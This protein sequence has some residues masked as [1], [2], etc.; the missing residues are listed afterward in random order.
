MSEMT[1][2]PDTATAV[3]TTPRTRPPLSPLAHLRHDLR[4][5]IG[6]ILG[7]A[8]ILMEDAA[9]AGQP[10]SPD[11]E[12]IYQ[13]GK[14]LLALVDERVNES[15]L[16]GHAPVSPSPVVRS[17]APTAT[18]PM[19]SAVRASASEQGYLLIADDNEENREIL[20]RQL[21]RLGH[22]TATVS[23]GAEAIALLATESFDLILLDL[24][25]P[26]LDGYQTLQQ[27]K[28]D[29]AIANTPVIMVTALD[30]IESAARCI[31]MGAADYLTKPFNPTLLRAR[32]N[33]SLRTKWARDRENQL[34]A[35]LQENYEKLLAAE[36]M[37][38]DLTGMIVHDLR[39]PLTSVLSG[40]M[41]IDSLGTLDSG[42]QEMLSISIHGAETLLGMINDLLDISK[43]EDGSLQ[44]EYGSVTAHKLIADAQK[45]VALLARNRGVTLVEALE[46]DLPS[47][48]GDDHKL[49]RALVNIL[50]NAIKFTPTGGSITLGARRTE[51]G[52]LLFSVQ[53]TG[54]G[55]PEDAF[56]RIFDKFGQVEN[57]KAGRKMSTGLGLTF[58]KMAVEAHGGRIWVESTMGVG[59]TFLFTVPL[60]P[61]A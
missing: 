19:P 41:T 6:H 28:S 46:P 58:C 48:T 20:S 34:T 37:R 40:L 59:S 16:S 22:R 38:D 13:S 60:S 17:V 18:Y 32:I 2:S 3:P 9:A 51:E 8:E 57:R 11:L 33:A 12:C 26:E 42:Q 29:P 49:H 56:Q 1:A 61:P 47:F 7:F 43:S 14:R 23:G 45:Q 24:M 21:E 4:T 5:P 54:E 27:I 52:E 44:L 53:D 39:T 15:L 36:K 31:E 55:I 10:A 25:M 30:E 50:G 35:E